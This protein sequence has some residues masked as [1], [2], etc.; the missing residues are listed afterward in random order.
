MAFTEKKYQGVQVGTTPS[1]AALARGQH[2]NEEVEDMP[3]FRNNKSK[4]SHAIR[5]KVAH[6]VARHGNKNSG[7]I[8][9]VGT[10]RN[11]TQALK[12]VQSWL[13]ENRL[14]EL[15]DLTADQANKYLEVR[16]T[17]VRQKTLDLD[18][19]AL[20]VLTEAKLDRVK[21]ALPPSKLA[22]STRAY[23]SEQVQTIVSGQN[24]RFGL[25]TELVCAA[26]L[27]ASELNTL[28][29]VAERSASSHRDWSPNRF[30][31]RE[32]MMYT[33]VGKGG[34]VTEKIIPHSLAV[35]LESRRLS[36]PV[37]VRD[38]G[39]NYERHYDIAGGKKWSSNFS[40][41]SKE[42]LDFSSGGH[43][44]RHFY[45]QQREVELQSRGYTMCEARG[46]VAQ[47]VGHF[48]PETTKGYER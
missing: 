48:S 36:A 31:G 3:S 29:P 6:G 25:A 21:S 1:D 42:I 41:V 33:V 39:I 13:D 40:K 18:R 8:H 2:Q 22:T 35:Q 45:V 43:G 4:A 23:T 9:S 24:E 34:L 28:R 44:L 10:E 20:Q 38:R 11:Y 15:K 7:L 14:G 46:I 37:N 19:Q 32:G 5:S 27:R 47:E 12:G 17:T 30:D 16:A 26:G